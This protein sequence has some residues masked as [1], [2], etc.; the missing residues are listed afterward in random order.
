VCP[1]AST[2]T[3]PSDVLATCNPVPLPAAPAC[4]AA[5]DAVVLL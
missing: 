3:L 1:D 4:G 2:S 5:S